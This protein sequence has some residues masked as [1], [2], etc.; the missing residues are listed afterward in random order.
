MVLFNCLRKSLD[1][2]LVPERRTYRRGCFTETLKRI[3]GIRKNPMLD[4]NHKS[5]FTLLCI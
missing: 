5:C 2:L 1:K 4:K 3:Y